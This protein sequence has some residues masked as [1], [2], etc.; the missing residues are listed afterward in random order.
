M[1]SANEQGTMSQDMLT[2]AIDSTRATLA[3]TMKVTE[4][5]AEEG[6]ADEAQAALE[7]CRRQA[8]GLISCLNRSKPSDQAY[9]QVLEQEL[10]ALEKTV[11]KMRKPRAM[12]GR[13]T[14]ALLV[15]G[16]VAVV[17]GF[18]VLLV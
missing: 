4:R 11:G 3:R 8:A 18:A 9:R 13:W 7:K 17:I 16:A 14:S 2:G 10:S 5:L 6:R 15:A 1:R 12:R